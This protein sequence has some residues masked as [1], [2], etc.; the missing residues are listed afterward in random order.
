MEVGRL[1]KKGSKAAMNAS[2]A[3][4]IVLETHK[5][6]I[7]GIPNTSFKEYHRHACAHDVKIEPNGHAEF[8]H[9]I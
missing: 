6:K 1:T 4:K 9:M 3:T 2:S 8:R 5:S 7:K